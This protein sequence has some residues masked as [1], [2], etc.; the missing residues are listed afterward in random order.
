MEY[1]KEEI[2]ELKRFQKAYSEKR[3]E[4]EEWN[5]T[6][7]ALFAAQKVLSAKSVARDVVDGKT[8]DVSTKID[9][10]IIDKKNDLVS[11]VNLLQQAV[12]E[13]KRH[14]SEK[15]KQD[16]WKAYP[17]HPK[18]VAARNAFEEAIK[19]I[20]KGFNLDNE[21]NVALKKDGLPAHIAWNACE[22][23]KFLSD[24]MRLLKIEREDE[25]TKA[26]A[27]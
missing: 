26:M 9:T 12:G 5:K 18:T 25:V 8:P 24:R 27:L 7:S 20:R 22:S 19:L 11:V 16:Y 13:Q 2:E 6:H 10:S 15:L 1:C 23:N 4:L 3:V 14:V 21:A 17:E